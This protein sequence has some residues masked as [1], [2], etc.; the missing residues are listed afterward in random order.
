MNECN[1]LL[2]LPLLLPLLLLRL[3]PPGL[4]PPACSAKPSLLLV[5]LL[6]LLFDVDPPAG[7]VRARRGLLFRAHHA[8]HRQND[9]HPEQ[10]SQ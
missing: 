1:V 3:L 9:E 8:L 2:Y 6:F 10:H 7:A 4:P 5:V